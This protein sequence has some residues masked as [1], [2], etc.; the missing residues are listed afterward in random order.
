MKKKF[1]TFPP[2]GCFREGPITE[3][4]VHHL[5][6]AGD[7]TQKS[8]FG[9]ATVVQ[10]LGAKVQLKFWCQAISST[11]HSISHQKRLNVFT[12]R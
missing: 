7:V 12:L 10:F 2:R 4:S 3:E 6:S 8:H 1:N 11:E 9:F 5:D